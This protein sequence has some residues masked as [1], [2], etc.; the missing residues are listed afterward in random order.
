MTKTAPKKLRIFWN[1]NAQWATSGYSNQI[2]ELLPRIKDEGYQQAICN[3]YGLQGGK[4]ILNDILQYPVINHTYGSDALIHHAKDFNADVVLSLMD[5]WVLNPTDLQQVNRWIPVVPIDHDPV[6][7]VILERL[8][9]AY[10]IVT[11]SRFG[12]KQLQDNGLYSTYIP[13]T[14]DTDIFKPVDKVERKKQSGLPADCFLVGM[15]A[16]NKD[17]PPRKSFQE[18]MD[19]FVM[20]LQKE[21]KAILYI[22]TNPEF[23]GG[24][25][26]RE[27]AAFLGIQNR[28]LFPDPY[29]MNFN[30]SKADMNLIYNTFDVLVGPS[31]SEGF[32]VPLIEAQAAGVPVITNNW[33]SMAELVK[34]GKT[35]FLTEVQSK[36]WSH[37]QSYTGIPSTQSIYNCLID[38]HKAD[39]KK[40]GESARAWMLEDYDSNKIFKEK[41]VPFFERLE[42]EIYPVESPQPMVV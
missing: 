32:G 16:A 9:F 10:R 31:I 37:L 12:Q 19:A 33:T 6:P 5:I 23:P 26:I 34:P 38:I 24:F 25:P 35:G 20:F 8:K 30:M 29:Q 39:R 40:M 27:Y 15:V 1:S 22:H 2:A 18:V 3:F 17:N 7:K 4:I 36:K 42:S 21:P 14:V 13:H 28:V 11:Y 41:W